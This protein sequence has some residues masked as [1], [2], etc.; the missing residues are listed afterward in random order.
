[1]GVLLQSYQLAFNNYHAQVVLQHLLDDIYCT[2]YKGTDPIELAYHNGRR[3]V[4]DDIL[5]NID[6]A[7]Q[8]AKYEPV[9]NMNGSAS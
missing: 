7:T 3:S 6:Y 8:P 9:E 1:M 5:R 4:I 2:V